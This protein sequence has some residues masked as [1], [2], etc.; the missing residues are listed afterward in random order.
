MLRAQNTLAMKAL[1]RS[2]GTMLEQ[3][4]CHQNKLVKAVM[5]YGT[6]LIEQAALAIFQNSNRASMHAS[7]NGNEMWRKR[8]G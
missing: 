8:I 1:L 2:S 4:S 7:E 5:S 6:V 3:S